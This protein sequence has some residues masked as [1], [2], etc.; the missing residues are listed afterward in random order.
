MLPVTL[1]AMGKHQAIKL[2]AFKAQMKYTGVDP[3]KL[4]IR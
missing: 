3:S 1:H 2:F 4:K